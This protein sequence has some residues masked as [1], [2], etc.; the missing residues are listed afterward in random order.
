MVTKKQKQQIDWTSAF[1]FVGN[2]LVFSVFVGV[3]SYLMSYLLGNGVW[4]S[5][6]ISSVFVS[7]FTVLY[8]ML[9]LGY[10]DQLIT[11]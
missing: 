7:S 2:V 1:F 10:S 11:K 9:W 8:T 4:F 5:L 6:I 3:G